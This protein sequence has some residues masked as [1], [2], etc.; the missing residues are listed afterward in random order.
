MKATRVLL[1]VGVL[2]LFSKFGHADEGYHVRG[3]RPRIYF[4]PEDLPRLRQ[5]MQNPA[6]A[7]DFAELKSYVL[8]LKPRG[9][10]WLNVHDSDSACFLYLLERDP[11]LL[12]VIRT[13]V[14]NLLPHEARPDPWTAG[15]RA[16]SLAIVYDWCYDVLSLEERRRLAVGRGQDRGAGLEA[17]YDAREGAQQAQAR[18][19]GSPP[20][21]PLARLQHLL[22]RGL[23]RYREAAPG[24][25]G[26]AEA[27]VKRNSEGGRM[28]A[29]DVS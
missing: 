17:L 16:R 21:H 24:R 8:G 20:H 28:K 19:R 5:R 26:R 11:Q 18:T 9:N 4:T 25:G 14:E 29:E 15:M 6:F 13:Y 7:G 2:C 10:M 3:E 27:G 22:L 23:P 1:V 12:P